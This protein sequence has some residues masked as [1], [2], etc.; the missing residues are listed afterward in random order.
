MRIELPEPCLVVL[1]GPSGSGKSTFA[2][3]H[4]LPTEI[5][6]S[7]YCRGVVSDDE[8][9]QSASRD[10]F[11][12]LEYIVRKRLA[13][14]KLTVI[15]ATNVRPE[16]RAKYP[17]LAREYHLL[18]VAIV[19]D[20][21][22]KF[23]EARNAS[24]P[25]RNFGGHVIR[26]QS[27]SLRRSLRDL[28]NRE[29]FKFT[30]TISDPAQVDD[31]EIS[32]K[33]LWTNRS[34][35]TGPFDIIGDIHG[36]FDETVDLLRELGWTVD[37]DPANPNA[38][39]SDGR[40]VIFLGDLVDR[41]PNSPA[42]LRL[43]MNMCA[44]GSAFCVPGNHENKLFRWLIG[45]NVKL[46]HGLAETVA[47]LEAEPPEFKDRV[48]S[49]IDGLVSHALLDGGRLVVAHAGIRE[50]MHGRSSGAVREFCLY[51]ETTGETDEY[52]LPVRYNW[53]A[54]YRG[55]AAVIYGHTPV[56]EA[57]WLNNTI[58][59]DTG[60]V[61]GG[62]LTAL[63]WPERKLVQVPARRE[64]YAPTKPLRPEGESLV[65]TSDRPHDVLDLEDVTGKRLI[66][67]R[68]WRPVT[69]REENST[70]ALEVMSRFS[71]DPRWLIHLP[72]TMSPC[73]TAPDGPL[74]ERPQEAFGYYRDENI[75]QVVCEQKHMGSRAVAI[76]C[77]SPEAAHRRF[78]ITGDGG[79]VLTRT[80][81]Q[82]FD[83]AMNAMVVDRLRETLTVAGFW[84]EFESDWFCLDCELMPWSA[85]AQSLLRG[86]YA[87]A[88]AAGLA[89]LGAAT[90]GLRAAIDRGGADPALL[91]R[92]E[93][94]MAAV[95]RYIDAYRRYC[96]AVAGLDDLKVAPFHVLASEGRV[97]TDKTHVW[98]METLAR[99]CS[100]R[101][102]GWLVATPWRLV[103]LGNEAEVAA[104]TAWWHELVA[105]GG[106]GMVVKPLEYL[107]NGRRGLVQPA[108]KC[109]G[110]E[111][112]RIIYG[113]EYDLA[114][115]LK[116]LR[117]RAVSS[118]RSLA[119]R[120]FALGVEALQRFVGNEGLWRVHECVFGVLALESEPVD[121]RL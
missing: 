120:E 82:F 38:T 73:E 114:D 76:V 96:W 84:E 42:V 2:R 8:N 78:G 117:Q 74:L 54:D 53:A 83:D 65:P 37:A 13:R 66:E 99:L 4:F 24:R 30:T 69:I 45:K 16:D 3:K 108:V 48:R 98:H 33:P 92:T 26:S 115:N 43:A 87:P 111:Y 15:D 40:R 97:H 1:V 36:C 121:P 32:R 19:F 100:A 112:L 79:I 101:N 49:F 72:P 107:A 75:H 105:A 39:R 22:P 86:Q 51:G 57:V 116:R 109:R 9:D 47:Q 55:K 62:K 88:G 41:G 106:E 119:F 28:R 95:R 34:A 10:A 46:T 23:C 44:S 21:A 93:T 102:D 31:I 118:K 91:E 18:A 90:N 85:K 25:D 58:C 27:A 56:P 61:F 17:A 81:R 20:F 64:Y 77:R 6:S 52:G 94:R 71:A 68:A 12:V 113:P 35:E 89:D 29:G 110:P 11:D 70:A 50:E 60:C 104:A 67:C 59:L 7:D 5:V 14:G 80:G 63:Q 103:D